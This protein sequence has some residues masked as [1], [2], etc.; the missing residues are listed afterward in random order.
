MNIRFII[1][2]RER[3]QAKIRRTTDLGF[4]VPPQ[5]NI[6]RVEL[7][8]WSSVLILPSLCFDAAGSGSF[9]QVGGQI[10]ARLLGDSAFSGRNS[11]DLACFGASPLLFESNPLILEQTPL[12]FKATP[13]FCSLS[14]I[15]RKLT[16]LFRK[17]TPLPQS[18]TLLSRITTPLPQSRTP[19][20][21][22]ATPMQPNRTLSPRVSTPSKQAATPSFQR[23]TPL[24]RIVTPMLRKTALS[25]RKQ[26]PGCVF[27]LLSLKILFACA[28]VGGADSAAVAQI[29]NRLYRRTAFGWARKFAAACGLPICDPCPVE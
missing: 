23:R 25:K 16:P 14:P 1:R 13:L 28:N 3:T 17:A 9:S 22:I 11:A 6:L 29:C 26:A 15:S 20:F 18:R 19:M 24:P 7:N 2:V 12:I 10:R 5:F 4:S 8:P 27:A 21:R